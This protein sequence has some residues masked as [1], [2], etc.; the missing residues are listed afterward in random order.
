VPRYDD[1]LAQAE[2]DLADRSAELAALQAKA[3]TRLK[4][5][6]WSWLDETRLPHQLASALAE[7]GVARARFRRLRA[8]PARLL[9]D[10]ET[11]INHRP[12]KAQTEVHTGLRYELDP[13]KRRAQRL[14]AG[15]GFTMPKTDYRDPGTWS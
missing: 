14:D 15:T 13:R 3:S 6:R 8:L 7:E 5:H 4:G 2:R 9:R 11:V 10:A 1:L 12:Q